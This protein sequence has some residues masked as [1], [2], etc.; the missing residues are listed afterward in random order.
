MHAAAQPTP[1]DGTFPLHGDRT[2][3]IAWLVAPLEPAPGDDAAPLRYWTLARELAARGHE[4]VWWTTD[5]DHRSL[6]RRRPPESLEGLESFL[7]KTLA[8]PAYGNRLGRRRFASHRAFADR[9]EKE[10]IQSVA[11]GRLERPDLLVASLPPLESAESA[12]RLARRLDAAFVVDLLENWPD[13]DLP[14]VAGPDWLRPLVFACASGSLRSFSLDSIRRR[15]GLVLDSADA[16]VAPSAALATAAGCRVDVKIL[17]IG[18]F[19]Q[20]FP[21]TKRGLSDGS[22]EVA[23]A[24]P[25]EAGSDP[26]AQAGGRRLTVLVDTEHL[27]DADADCLVAA[28]R[29]LARSGLKARVPFVGAGRSRRLLERA[30]DTQQAGASCRLSPVGVGSRADWLRLL[31]AGDALIAFGPVHE[32]VPIPPEICE[33]AAAGL[34]LICGT[35]QTGKGQLADLVERYGA[36]VSFPR[37]DAAA[38]A[39]AF[40]RLVTAGSRLSA[41]AAGARRLAE[42]EFDRERI[43]SRYADWLESLA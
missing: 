10:A 21:A 39:A 16:V 42:A 37:P 38:L 30:A 8:V 34:A 7:L 3:L 18:A 31:G 20:E 6:S 43:C 32:P 9:F 35:D 26:S 23:A 22:E 41:A 13:S 33:S 17:P 29:I 24:E 15:R 25:S 1:V 40:R 4:V 5:F 11:E 27:E 36:G 19:P 2:P 28:V 12:L 14:L